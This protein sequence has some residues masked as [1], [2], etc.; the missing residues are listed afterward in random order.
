MYVDII[1]WLVSPLWGRNPNLALEGEQGLK[2]ESK[3]RA[4]LRVCL[5]SFPAGH[6]EGTAFGLSLSFF[7]V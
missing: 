6:S 5:P 3:H 2:N 1:I 7:D 4:E